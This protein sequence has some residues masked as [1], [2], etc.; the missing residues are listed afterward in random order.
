MAIRRFLPQEHDRDMAAS[1]TIEPGARLMARLRAKASTPNLAAAG[2]FAVALI[3]YVRTLLPGVSFGDWADAQLN[4][5]R[6]GILH[7]TGYPLYTLLGKLFSLIPVASVAYRANLLSAVAAAGVAGM[8][9]LIM[10]RLG[11]RPVIAIGAALCLAVTGTLWQEATFSEMNGLHLLLVALLLHRA[12]VWRAER[13]D[14]DLLMGAL[15]GGLCASNHGLAITVVPL[16]IL[17]VLV[18]ARREIAVHPVVLVRAAGAFVLGLVPYLY[19]PLRAL[20]GP[21]EVYGGFLTPDGLFAYVSGAQ[22]RGDMHFTSIE[23]LSTAWAA[24]PSVIGDLVSLS[25]VVFVVMGVVGVAVLLR[26][27]HWFGLLLLV[28]GAVNV[29]FYANYL[30]DLSHYLL[31]TWLI[32]AIGL[33]VATEAVVS[34]VAGRTR[35]GVEGIQYGIL[36]LALVM[37]VSNWATH[38][39]S[40]NR[41]GERFAT[42]V[43]AAL[44]QDAVLLTYWDALT[45]LSYE[46]C[47]EGVRPDVSLRAYDERAFV[48]CDPVER[49]LTDVVQRRPVFAL[50]V[51]DESLAALTHLTPVPVA[52]IRLPWGRRYPELDRPLYRL[53]PTDVVP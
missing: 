47:I 6:L 30:G 34:G 48:T 35:P 14:R 25:N 50:M 41:D 17:F 45:P 7:P 20:A 22:F 36:G 40:A 19:L 10:V 28:L 49:P 12:L 37:L 18:D 32:L 52:T 38:D 21:S 9:V 13:R 8:A 44:P 24:M 1:P 51:H 23:S 53:V 31:T 26:R 27:D 5:A 15:L 4:P 33:A 43:F 3:L 39:Q 29:Y 42:E 2:V 46:H 11:V 16:V